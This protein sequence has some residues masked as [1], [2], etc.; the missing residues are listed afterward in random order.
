MQAL[1][2][3]ADAGG[4]S[5]AAMMES[6]GR[7]TAEVVLAR[8]GRASVLVLAGPGNN[9]GDGLVC[10]RHLHL[11][12]V[13][14]RVYLWKRRTDPEGDYEGHFAS[15]QRLGVPTMH[16]DADAGFATL[17]AWLQTAVVVDALLGTG[18]N[19]PIAGQLATILGLTA[20]AQLQAAGTLHVVAVDCA[21]GLDCDTGE[22]SIGA[23]VPERTVTFAYAKQGHFRFPGA[24]YVGKLTVA[25]IGIPSALG[26]AVHTFVLDAAQVA[27]WL[28]A[29]PR[30]SHKGTFGKV[31]VAGGSEHFPG[32]PALACAAAARTGAGLVTG[33]LI[34]SVWAATAARLMEPTY[35]LLPDAAGAVAA[36]AAPIVAE[37]AAGYDALVLGPGLSN[38]AQ[39]REFVHSLLG[40]GLPP[41]L[42]DAD[43]LNTLAQL[44][45]WPRRLPAACV[46]T[47]HPAEMG[48][49]CGLTVAEVQSQ[50]WE[51][52]RARA[53]EWGCVVLLKGPFT[54]V[55]AP[56]GWLAVVPIATPALAT[57]GSGDVLAGIVGA[58]LAQGV[59]PFAAACAGAW[60]HGA[61][62]LR[63]AAVIGASGVIASDLV[64]QIPA[65]M[66]ELRTSGPEF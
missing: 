51:L 50:R 8:Y 32:A 46:L 65:V 45:G 14:V 17:R 47:P 13:P 26:E 10:A 30:V 21:S 27:G 44:D 49:L 16:A 60:I 11:A 40:P 5:F 37:A 59:A 36:S 20:A 1:E 31:L 54:V 7:Q 33:A 18:A 23:L 35:L 57:A 48:R 39:T 64:G 15:L 61:C 19:R 6:A 52:A 25:D 4:H 9:G 29:R 34:R 53:Q 22:V 56:D 43:G 58:L 66:A 55:A 62:G 24:D 3:A 42:L 63:C 28:P 38:T 2:R 41:T 12:G